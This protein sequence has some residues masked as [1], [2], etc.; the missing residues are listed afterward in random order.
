MNS[1]IGFFQWVK[2]QLQEGRFQRKLLSKE[3]CVVCF[4]HIHRSSISYHVINRRKS[5]FLWKLMQ[6]RCFGFR[7]GRRFLRF[8]PEVRRFLNPKGDHNREKLGEYLGIIGDTYTSAACNIPRINLIY[9]LIKLAKNLLK[10]GYEY[11]ASLRSKILSWI[12]PGNK[13]APGNSLYKVN[14]RNTKTMCQ[15]WSKLTKIRHQNDVIDAAL[16]SSFLP[17]RRFHTVSW[18]IH[19][20]LWAS[21]F[22][23]G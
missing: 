11:L 8:Q 2:P 16:M 13:I 20:W 18:F 6:M 21:K 22:R 3:F 7:F 5:M 12:V 19:C 23:L 1:L 4:R 14:N 17:S 9:L 15:I 10:I